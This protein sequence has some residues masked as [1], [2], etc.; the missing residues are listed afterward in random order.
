MR[1]KQ[2]EGKVT[3]PL[4]IES[5]GAAVLLAAHQVWA[6]PLTL[7]YSHGSDNLVGHA[8]HLMVLA[9]S[10]LGPV[11]LVAIWV[12]F[13]RGPAERD[14]LLRYAVASVCAFVALSKVLSPQYLIWLIPLVPIVRDRRGTAA[15]ALLVAAMFLTQLWF[16]RRFV[17]RL[18][19]EVLHRSTSTVKR[20]RAATCVADHAERIGQLLQ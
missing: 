13:A 18:C 5:L 11:C 2:R 1:R 7:V 17:G 19:T 8:P 3:R 4:Q 14:R 15:S 20:W 10:V 12:A 16:P 6:L 9:Q